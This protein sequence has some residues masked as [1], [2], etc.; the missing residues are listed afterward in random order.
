[1]GQEE[2]RVSSERGAWALNERL[3][4]VSSHFFTDTN[5]Y[6]AASAHH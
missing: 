1:M 5:K 3:I 2:P 6:M 4:G